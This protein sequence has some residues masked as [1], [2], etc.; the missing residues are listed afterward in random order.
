MRSIIFHL[1]LTCLVVYSGLIFAS[2]RQ[3]LVLNFGIYASDKPSEMVSQF[4][5]ALDVLEKE[6]NKSL[7]RAVKIKMK[8]SNSYERSIKHLVNG[9]VDFTRFGPASYVISKKME[10]GIQILANEKNREQKK[11]SGVIA[12]KE[13]S[14]I[15]T[16]ADLK[17]KYFAFGNLNSTTGRYFPQF[18][19]YKVGIKA[20]DLHTYDYLGR[21]D[22]VAAA[23]F[24]GRYDAGAFKEGT[25][26]K[27][28]NKG[29]KYKILAIFPN[30]S[31]PWLARAH[32]EHEIFVALQEALLNFKDSNALAKL[33]RAGF[34]PGKDSDY[35]LTRMSIENNAYFYE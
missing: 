25:L 2:N 6:L 20:S 18:K 7:N 1:F 26:R 32:M 27:F 23:V 21:H 22:R 16:L 11:F 4:R 15:R 8:V 19:L 13:N 35:A 10:P 34:V 30:V 28:E 31:K 5:P 17:G 29:I 9:Q 12:V 24:A 14:E 33:K 3:P